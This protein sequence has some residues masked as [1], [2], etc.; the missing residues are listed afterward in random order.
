MVAGL[1]SQQIQVVGDVLWD[2]QAA[3]G[4][5]PTGPQFT[6]PHPF[7]GSRSSRDAA[8]AWAPARLVRANHLPEA[9]EVSARVY[10]HELVRLA[11]TAIE[12]LKAR[13]EGGQEQ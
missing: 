6:D 8:L 4:C 5:P 10:Q 12:S 13:F 11:V 9:G 1:R 7:H 3:T 2:K